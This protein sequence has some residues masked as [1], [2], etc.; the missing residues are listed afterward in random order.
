L[1]KALG[2]QKSFAIPVSLPRTLVIVSQYGYSIDVML[3]K[4]KHLVFSS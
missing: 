4:A 3:S 2:H 1:E